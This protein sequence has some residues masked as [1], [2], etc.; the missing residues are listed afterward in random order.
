MLATELEINRCTQLLEYSL[1]LRQG[2]SVGVVHDPLSSAEVTELF[3]V[4]ATRLGAR[5]SVEEV[6]RESPRPSYETEVLILLTSWPY[7]ATTRRSLLDSGSRILSACTLGKSSIHRI[8]E[9]DCEHVLA[10]TTRVAQ[11]YRSG[12]YLTAS[13]RE[14]GLTLSSEI[15]PE[16]VLAMDGRARFPGSLAIVPF[17]VVSV[18]PAPNTAH[19]TMPVNGTITGMGRIREPIH[20]HVE[21][22]RIAEV[23]GARQAQAL[24]ALLESKG[25]GAVVVAES[26]S[27]TNLSAQLTGNIVEDERVAGSFHVGLGGN[28][29]LGGDTE[30]AFHIDLTSIGADVR[31]DAG[32]EMGPDQG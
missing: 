20:L 4:A 30:F 29:H 18:V 11:L 1:A 32:N 2:E 12:R 22:G 14:S 9:T 19:G 13:W 25:P 26:G 27:G 24:N 23:E 28:T 31:I 8:L 17:G 16:T 10:E 7:P 15:R 5:V 21:D 6:T 3:A